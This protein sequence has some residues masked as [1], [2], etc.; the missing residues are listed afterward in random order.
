MKL[1]FVDGHNLI[2]TTRALTELLEQEGERASREGAEALILA[3]ARR[4]RGVRVRLVYDG[5]DLAGGHPGSRDDGPLAVRFAHPPSEADD[6][7][8]YEAEEAAKR[9]EAVVLVTD[10]KELGR[11]VRRTGGRVLPVSSFYR[12]LTQPPESPEEEVPFTEREKLDLAREILAMGGMT[13][14]GT[15]TRRAGEGASRPARKPA[16]LPKRSKEERRRRFQEK[17]KARPGARKGKSKK[18]RRGF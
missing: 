8:V 10:D 17:A 2:L 15:S 6:Q 11:K 18:K 1:Y 12:L 13:E 16:V 3:G 4:T 9:G 5:R 7:I 14:V